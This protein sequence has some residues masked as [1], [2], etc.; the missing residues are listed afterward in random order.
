[1][2][3]AFEEIGLAERLITLKNGQ[4]VIDYIDKVTEDLTFEVSTSP[5]WP[6]PLLLLDINMPILTGLETLPLVK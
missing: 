4:E 5:L 3:L 6:I 1:M 2:K